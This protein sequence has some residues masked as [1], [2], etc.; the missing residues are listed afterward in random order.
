MKFKLIFPLLL[1][2]TWSTVYAAQP[3]AQKTVD[4]KYEAASST[5]KSKTKK[6]K[7]KKSKQQQEAAAPVQ[8]A[9][10]VAC[11]VNIEDITDNR[12]NKVTLGTNGAEPLIPTGLE[13]WLTDI[14]TSEMVNKTT[15]WK[16]EKVIT[17]KPSLTK[18][19]A[20][21]EN[22]NIHGVFSLSVDITTDGETIT[23][24]YRGMGSKANMINGFGEYATAL[25]YAVKETMPRVISDIEAICKSS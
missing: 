1:A 24:K 18:L 14:K 7:K 25:N 20:Y 17:V 9:N 8:A 11:N 10:S 6:V 22:A 16:G 15:N 5:K 13:Q 3:A 21:A 12:K 4:L 2:F 19:Y 23:K